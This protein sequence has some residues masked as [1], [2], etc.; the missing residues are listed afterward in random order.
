MKKHITLAISL[1][2]LSTTASAA[3][4]TGNYQIHDKKDNAYTVEM[5]HTFETNTTFWMEIEGSLGSG[6]MNTTNTMFA[7][8]QKMFDADEGRFSMSVGLH[9][10]MIDGQTYVDEDGDTLANAQYRPAV[11]ASYNWDNGIYYSGRFRLHYDQD[12]GDFL[13]NR[14]DTAVGW[15][16][17]SYGL[18]YKN[19]YLDRNTGADNSFDHEVRYTHF[20]EN[21][22]WAPYVEYRNQPMMT[23]GIE[24]TRN[25]AF[26]IGATV[27][28]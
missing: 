9:Y 12:S 25:S 27:G 15:R 6:T 10:L 21:S 18:Q 20:F 26:V 14:L 22:A 4:L 7:L 24:E 23:N 3:Y 2:L 17:D 19:I 1:A 13:E 5:G 11:M 16:G 8:E 28:F